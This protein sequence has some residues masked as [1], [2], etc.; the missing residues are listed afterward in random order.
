[1][2]TRLLIIFTFALIPFVFP[3]VDASCDKQ[4]GH[5]D[6]SCTPAELLEICD[7]LWSPRY[8]GSTTPGNI[9]CRVVYDLDLNEDDIRKLGI[10]LDWENY[11]IESSKDFIDGW[12]FYEDHAIPD[13]LQ[14][15]PSI[16]MV[17]SLPP[18]MKVQISFDYVDESEI[19]RFDESINIY[20]KY[21]GEIIPLPENTWVI[22][23]PESEPSLTT[24]QLDELCRND[25]ALCQPR[26]II[27]GPNVLT[28]K[29]NLE[30]VFLAFIVGSIGVS[31]ILGI[32]YWRKRN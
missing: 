28:P 31:F 20:M 16:S 10:H 21:N 29:N 32:I 22:M 4:V 12:G 8:D 30:D 24:N 11:A 14:I 25:Q 17:D 26:I 9:F 1:M 3:N 5:A 6:E 7:T 18:D 2:K 23:P 27:H 19:K 15:Y 13:T